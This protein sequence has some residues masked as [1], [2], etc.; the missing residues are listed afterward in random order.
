MLVD[1]RVCLSLFVAWQSIFVLRYL[2]GLFEIIANLA[3]EF[4]LRLDWRRG[5][6]SPCGDSR[7][8]RHFHPAGQ[9]ALP[10]RP[11]ALIELRINLSGLHRVYRLRIAPLHPPAPS[12]GQ[13]RHRPVRAR[14]GPFIN[15]TY[16]R[17]ISPEVQPGGEENYQPDECPQSSQK[18]R[19]PDRNFSYFSIHQELTYEPA[20]I[21]R[22]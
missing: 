19:H 21:K 5:R 10:A 15:Q 11:L 14:P 3:V 9:N 16:Q 6:I 4:L 13:S 20:P 22:A 7:T 8:H 1:F 2:S 12:V 18:P 17:I